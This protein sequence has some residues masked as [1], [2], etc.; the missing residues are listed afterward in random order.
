MSSKVREEV[1]N[2]DRHT[3][4]A[5]VRGFPHFCG[6]GLH[7][8]HVVLRSQKQGHDPADLLTVC[9]YAHDLIHNSERKLAEDYGLIRRSRPEA[10]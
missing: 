9:L 10:G 6:G 7:V 8:H 4:Q 3:C 5:A 2:R 1:L